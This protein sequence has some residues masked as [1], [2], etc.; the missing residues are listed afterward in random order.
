MER[1]PDTRTLINEMKNYGKAPALNEAK[2]VYDKDV[3]LDKETAGQLEDAI[4]NVIGQVGGDWEEGFE[5]EGRDDFTNIEAIEAALDADNLLTIAKDEDAWNLANS[6]MKRHGY[7]K[8]LKFLD[9]I[10]TVL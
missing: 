10:M 9:K 2:R 4:S 8:V 5:Y 3:K 1:L 7:K 6:L